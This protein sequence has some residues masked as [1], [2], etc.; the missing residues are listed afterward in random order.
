M[1]QMTC[2]RRALYDY[3]YTSPWDIYQLSYNEKHR[4]TGI[5]IPDQIVSPSSPL[6]MVIFDASK[7]D[8]RPHNISIQL[9]M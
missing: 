7:K 8:E 3:Y 2:F 1:P 5:A 4:K 6:E 9:C